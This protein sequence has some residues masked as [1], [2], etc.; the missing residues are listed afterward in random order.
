[1]F[2]KEISKFLPKAK[3][4]REHADYGDF[5]ELP[6]MMRKYKSAEQRNL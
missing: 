3:D 6:K 5:V 1:L 4:I 2:P